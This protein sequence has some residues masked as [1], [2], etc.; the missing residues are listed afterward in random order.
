M[1][2]EG[3]GE[4]TRVATQR[5]PI[6]PQYK[7]VFS[8]GNGLYASNDFDGARLNGLSLHGDS[9]ITALITPENTPI[10]GSPWYSFKLWA[11]SAKQVD[12]KLTYLH[13]YHHRYF[14]KISAD[15][16]TWKPI[17]SSK[18]KIEKIP[19][20][21]TSAI[22]SLDL[23]RDTLWLSAQEV[24]TSSNVNSWMES[25]ERYSFVT[26]EHIGKS[27]LGKAIDGLVIGNAN[28][29]S[30]IVVM[31]R[32]HP[33]EVTGYLA[34]QSFVETIAGQSP[35]ADS[36]RE[37]FNTYVI[38]LVNPDGVN[39]GHWRHAYG[40]VDLN[41]DWGEF[42]HPETLAIRDY[43]IEK[44][45]S[46]GGKIYFFADFHSTWHDIYYTIDPTQKGNMPG[47]VPELIQMV[48]DE[49]SGYNPNVKPSP[50]RGNTI[51]SSS[52]FF[53][54]FGAESLIYEL[55][56][57]TPRSFIKRKGALTAT[58]L[59]ELLIEKAPLNN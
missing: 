11:E 8:I 27:S 56:D 12:L 51:T 15:G 19:G 24:I 43:F 13:G 10:N 37:K 9:L 14:P 46:S 39:N 47:L 57:N 28:D 30:M 17:D 29:K 48:G 21:S 20:G 45:K 53:S 35:L 40:G 55:G 1:Q 33:P 34:M 25:L 6:Q 5:V 36:F 59:M 44:V 26:K 41:R 18:V 7:G 16:D 3:Q 58:K 4:I 54:R 50:V 2:W 23:S 49:L 32:Q 38:P 42:N 31:S 22:L 52:Y